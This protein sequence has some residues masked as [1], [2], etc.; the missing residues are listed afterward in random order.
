MPFDALSH[1]VPDLPSALASVSALHDDDALWPLLHRLLVANAPSGGALLPGGIG[2]EIAAL[3]SELGLGDRWLGELRHTGNAALWLGADGPADVVVVAHMDRPSFRVLDPETGALVPVCANRFPDGDYHTG[4]KALRFEDGRLIV[5]AAGT[6]VS[7]RGAEGD[8]LRFE[9]TQ[10]ALAWQDTITMHVEPVRTAAGEVIG[11]GLDNVLGVLTALLA[12]AALHRVEDVLRA[13]GARVLV[14]FSDQEE[15]PPEAFFGHG[16]A[17]LTYAVP[18]P[19]GSVIVDAH[20]ADQEAG[21]FM[22]GGV[23]HGTLSGWGRG[24][25]VPPNYHALARD[26]APGVNGARPDTVQFSTGYLSRSDDMALGRWS[27]ILALIGPPMLNAH[28]G[29]ETAQIADIRSGAWWLS[30]FLAA[31][32][33]LPP[34]LDERYALGR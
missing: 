30:Y 14:V 7:H 2:G 32:L 19:R 28:T 11:T 23:S 25:L 26:L 31:A 8:S 27:K 9:P 16:A 1:A 24:S 10:G 34:E 21:P 4:A 20:A 5:G 3:A 12:A 6:I 13:R 29:H 15:G 22:G 17:R 33:N 18:P